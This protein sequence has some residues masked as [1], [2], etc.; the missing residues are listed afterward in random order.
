MPLDELYTDSLE[1]LKAVWHLRAVPPMLRS[2]AFDAAAIWSD[3]E[4]VERSLGADDPD[5]ALPDNIR[6]PRPSPGLVTGD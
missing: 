4:L 2:L 1:F 6:P 5:D 3:E